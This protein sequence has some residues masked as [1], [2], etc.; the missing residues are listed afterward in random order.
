MVLDFQDPDP[1][2]L[3]RCMEPDLWYCYVLCSCILPQPS[4]RKKDQK[5][6]TVCIHKRY[7]TILTTFSHSD[8]DPDLKPNL[9]NPYGF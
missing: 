8:A 5:E 6:V 3:A 9:S 2:P 7:G 4:T 1:D